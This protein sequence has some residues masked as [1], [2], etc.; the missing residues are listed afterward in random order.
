MKNL[1]IFGGQLKSQ[2]MRGSIKLA[3]ISIKFKRKSFKKNHAGRNIE[4]LETVVTKKV[5]VL[6]VI[7][8]EKRIV[9][10]KER[11]IK[12]ACLELNLSFNDI[13]DPNINSV[14][15]LKDLG[16]TNYNID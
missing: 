6:I 2:K 15:I 9:K 14:E 1:E 3:N 16:S 4:F 11:V 13:I 7:N 12:K 8:E 10:F 5:E